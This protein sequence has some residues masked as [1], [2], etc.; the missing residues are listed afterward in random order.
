M[1][2]LGSRWIRREAGTVHLTG[3]VTG[4]VIPFP[5][6]SG[7]SKVD[8]RDGPGI[9]RDRRFRLKGSLYE[10][11]PS[12]LIDGQTSG[13]IR[14]FNGARLS[15]DWVAA[16]HDCSH[17]RP[18]RLAHRRP[19]HVSDTECATTRVRRS[20]SRT[21]RDSPRWGRRRGSDN[22]RRKPAACLGDI[23][24]EPHAL[25]PLPPPNNIVKGEMSVL[26]GQ[27]GGGDS[28]AGGF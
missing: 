21:R 1:K 6:W 11:R 16:P 13:T 19:A 2:V 23:V 9:L 7:F 26:I 20:T 24:T 27:G 12:E 14:R 5:A 4:K 22:D 28:A 18:A 15:T 8:P 10:V 3:P 17:R 25:I